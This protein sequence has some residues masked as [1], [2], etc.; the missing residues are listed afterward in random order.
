MEIIMILVCIVFGVCVPALLAAVMQ[1]IKYSYH[2]LVD[3]VREVAS[4]LVWGGMWIVKA[5][6]FFLRL[7][8]NPVLSYRSTQALKKSMVDVKPLVRSFAESKL[9]FE[10]GVAYMEVSLANGPLLVRPPQDLILA[11]LS[12]RIQRQD[13]EIP[14][15]YLPTSRPML[16][17]ELVQGQVVLRAGNDV[18]GHGVRVTINGLNGMLTAKHVLK[19]LYASQDRMF[20]STK[21]SLPFGEFAIHGHLKG[22][23]LIFVDIPSVQWSLVGI[24][25]ATIGHNVNQGQPLS[26]MAETSEGL[27]QCRGVVTS[28]GGEFKHSVS[29]QGGFSGAP[30]FSGGKVVGIHVR[31]G[32]DY[33]VGVAVG[34][35]IIEEIESSGG[36]GESYQTA[37][38]ISMRDE[39]ERDSF[40]YD[41]AWVTGGGKVLKALRFKDAT[42]APISSMRMLKVSDTKSGFLWSDVLDEDDDWTPE[43]EDRENFSTA[44]L[45]EAFAAEIALLKE[46]EK[47]EKIADASADF[48]IGRR[49]VQPSSGATTSI[50]KEVGS[51]SKKGEKQRLKRKAQRATKALAKSAVVV[52]ASA[53]AEVGKIGC[54]TLS[55]TLNSA[56]SSGPQQALKTSSNL[57][58]STPKVI[59]KP[60]PRKMKSS[61][62]RGSSSKPATPHAR[63]IPK[64]MRDFLNSLKLKS[65]VGVSRKWL[66]SEEQRELMGEQ[67]SKNPMV[68]KLLA[69]YVP[70][71]KSS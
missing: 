6:R 13:S 56:S 58:E 16:M 27:V 52:T 40:T 7:V 23:D 17:T 34:P 61:Q 14:E 54:Q 66:N 70:P 28:P 57:L 5:L 53:S 43:Y 29:T 3:T 30:I 48:Q 1:L 42:M 2:E 51:P 9:V 55:E 26:I 11:L 68:V 32:P 63:P 31:G 25:S 15:T 45:S 49:P 22:G 33:N 50:K 41:R 71:S 67:Y 44:K 62:S 59:G 69:T 8:V 37:K 65:P 21:K 47:V 24:K 4:T 39:I 64:V 36:A 19:T 35:W 46:E 18:I 10:G 38:G 12:Q 20:G 60:L